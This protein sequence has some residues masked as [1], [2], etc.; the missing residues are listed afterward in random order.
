MNLHDGN[1]CCIVMSNYMKYY[2]KL[3]HVELYQFEA[4]R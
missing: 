4:K 2:Y 3:D 1:G